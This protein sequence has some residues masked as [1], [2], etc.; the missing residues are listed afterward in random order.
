MNEINWKAV[1]LNLLVVFRTLMETKSVSL[2]AD[3]LFVGQSAM[4]H[5]LSRLRE[6]LNDPL[7]ERQGHKMI[8]TAKA[9]QLYPMIDKVLQTI[10]GDILKAD[11]FKASEFSGTFKIGM[12]D[13]AE[14]LFAADIFDAIHQL[15]PKA[16][17]CFTTVD[18]A[19]YQDRFDS[20]PLDLVIG[21]M[22]P[23]Q[24][25][26]QYQKL[27]TEKHVCMWDGNRHQFKTPITLDDYLSLPHAL[28]SPDGSLKTGV[29][30]QLSALGAERAVSVASK[31]FLTIRHLMKKRDLI[32]VVPELM[33]QLDLFSE[34]L[35]HSEPPIEVGEFDIQLIWQTRNKENKRYQWLKEL[36][37]QT[38]EKSVS[39][40]KK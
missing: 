22:K 12:T 25:D 27:Y 5:S 36:L 1:D 31:H 7:F 18:K 14:L 38:I 35:V 24:K 4:S 40:Y 8:P 39:A 2:A 11:T 28:V 19:N 10:T 3:R 26:L 15:A 30:K 17:L 6:L 33:A 21:S 9:I 37:I 20:E 16:K 29:D 34:Q 23:E 13:Y 32:C